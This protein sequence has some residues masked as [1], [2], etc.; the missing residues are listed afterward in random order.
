MLCWSMQI[1]AQSTR[2]FACFVRSV[3]FVCVNKSY[4]RNLRIMILHDMPPIGIFVS[5]LFFNTRM[6]YVRVSCCCLQFHLRAFKRKVAQN[7]CGNCV[8]IYT[9][10]F[11]LLW[12]CVQCVGTWSSFGCR[13]GEEY[14]LFMYLL[15]FN[16][17]HVYIEW[18]YKFLLIFLPDSIEILYML[19]QLLTQVVGWPSVRT[20]YHYLIGCMPVWRQV[21][22]AVLEISPC[23]GTLEPCSVSGR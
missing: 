14:D 17:F 2:Q 19:V 11:L 22:S 20:Y 4:V 7:A 3:H 9:F 8:T 12:A 21:E 16:G 5:T 10:P 23:V 13:C 1:F 6:M 18:M 15:N